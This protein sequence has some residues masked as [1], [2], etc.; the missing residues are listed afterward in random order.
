MRQGRMRPDHARAQ[1]L[2]D[3]QGPCLVCAQIGN[4]NTGAA[5]PIDEIA[6]IARERGAWLHVDGAFGLWAATTRSRA[7]RWSPAS[8]AADSIA[9][10]AHKWLVPYDSGLVLTGASGGASAFA[11]SCP[12]HYMQVTPGEREPRSFTPDESRRA[13]GLPLYAA[14]RVPR[15]VEGIRRPRGTAAAALAHADG[16]ASR[17]S[18]SRPYPA[19]TWC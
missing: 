9:T 14:L 12:R 1:A 13:R 11:R 7:A 18:R 3:G 10:D 4:V 15:P 8:N 17:R 2:R 19:T 16:I 5:D 6:S